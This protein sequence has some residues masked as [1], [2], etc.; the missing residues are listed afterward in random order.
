VKAEIPENEVW[1]PARLRGAGGDAREN[2]FLHKPSRA[3]QIFR[4]ASDLPLLHCP[5]ARNQIDY[6]DDQRKHEQQVDESTHRVTGY[7]T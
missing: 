5:T 2:G 1:A 6:Q 4:R 3:P 7:Q